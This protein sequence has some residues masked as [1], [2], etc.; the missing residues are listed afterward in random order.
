MRGTA[1]MIAVLLASVVPMSSADAQQSFPALDPAS[2]PG[3]IVTAPAPVVAPQPSPVVA[4]DEQPVDFSADEVTYNEPA[5]IVMAMGNVDMMQ[6]GQHLR[7]DSVS[8]AIDAD[9]VQAEGNVVLTMPN[10]DVHKATSLELTDQM[11]SGVIRGMLSK[12]TDGSRFTA[13]EGMRKAGVRTVMKDASYTP[14]NVCE[15][16]PEPL[17]QIK[18]DKVIHDEVKKSVKYENARMEF[19]GVPFFYT[20]MFAHPDPSVKR[21]SGF[22]RPE[23]G[24]TSDT[25]AY[26]EGA[27]YFGDIAPEID[28]TLRLRPTMERGILTQGEYRQR[29]E[30]GSLEIEAGGV[31]SDRDEEDGRIETNRNRGHVFANGLFNLSDTWR[32]GFNAEGVSDKSYLRLYDIDNKDILENTMYLERL[33]GRDYTNVRALAFRDL[34][35]GPRP[36]QPEIAPELVHRMIGA[37]KATLG[38]RWD[39]GVSSMYLHRGDSDEQDVQRASADIGWERRFVADAGLVS[40]VRTSARVDGYKVLDNS[41]IP[42]GTDDET[43]DVRGNA[44]LS[45]VSSYPLQKRFDSV[46]WLVEPIFG[47]ALSPQLDETEFD[48]PN[49]DSLDIM[50]DTSNLFSNNRFAG[51]DRQEDGARIAYGFKTG[52]FDDGGKYGTVY[53]GQTRRFDDAAYYPEGSGLEDKASAY[54]GQVSLGLHEKLQ[55]DYRIQLD[56]DNFASQR[57]EFAATS[58]LGGFRNTG[59]YLYVNGIQGTDFTETREQAE[60]ASEYMFTPVWRGYGGALYDLGEEPGLRRARLGLGYADECFSFA[61]E[62]ARNLTND[63]AG[64]SETVITARIGFKN[65][66]EFSGPDVTLKTETEE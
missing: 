36:K 20:P 39:L 34:R 4:G 13:R 38:G 60:L 28:A 56:S 61:L 22:L 37:P 15:T 27:Y 23:Y 50:V 66:G 47:A 2:V 31:Q 17:W 64:E 21:K 45:V 16:N 52:L 46:S 14:C 1:L 57:H 62:G 29:F 8:Y 18:A 6:D 55:A 42:P 12:L 54:V 41:L 9:K 63:A 10:G 53:I 51:I 65:I 30:R 49:E 43:S 35:L 3:A 32:A 5:Q 24:W 25:G 59:R 33:S 26:F 58:A 11:R 19:A 48:I 40:T 7:A 44:V